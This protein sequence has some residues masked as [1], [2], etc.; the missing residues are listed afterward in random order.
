MSNN[1]N[2]GSNGGGATQT[3]ERCV[4]LANGA[5]SPDL[6]VNYEFG[7]V[8]GVDEFRQEQLYFLEKDRLHQRGL[9]GY[10]TVYGLG[11]TATA[12]ADASDERLIAVQPGLGIDQ[13]GRNIVLREEQCAR[14][15]AWLAGQIQ[16]G[17]A[18]PVGPFED[19]R[20]Y[21]V[22]TYDECEDAL[23]P[24]PGQ[25]CSTADTTQAP[26]RIRDG[27]QIELRWAPPLMTAWDA[28]RAFADVLA[29][30]RLVPGLAP[31]LSQEQEVIDLVRE[32]V[33]PP[34]MEMCDQTV[35]AGSPP[36]SP[37][38]SPPSGSPPTQT[39]QMPEEGAREALDRIFTVWVT[40]VRPHIAQQANL[41]DTDDDTK[42]ESGIL[43]AC[44]DFAPMDDF[45][46]N[47]PRIDHAHVSYVGRPYLLHTQ[48]I[49]EMLLL[50]NGDFEQRLE[51]REFA[52]LQ[53]LDGHTL[54]AWL[55]HP[56]PLEAVPSVVA[57]V[58]ILVDGQGVTLQSASA[59]AGVD[60]L[61]EIVTAVGAPN[62]LAP[63]SR[64]EAVFHVDAWQERGG[65]PLAEALEAAQHT[66][67]GR[68]G[69]TIHVYN[70]VDPIRPSRDLVSFETQRDDNGAMRLT[71]WFHTDQAVR[72]P[73]SVAVRREGGGAA[74]QFAASQI[75]GTGQFSFTWGF[76]PP[77]GTALNE[78][79]TLIF[80]FDARAIR[81]RNNQVTLADVIGDQ[82]L[83]FEGY[84][85]DRLVNVYYEVER[86]A[87]ATQ[88]PPVDI[89]EIIRQVAVLMPA[90]PF[91]D[92]TPRINQDIVTFEMWFHL[93]TEPPRDVM[94]IVEQPDFE[95]F[96]ETNEPAPATPHRIDRTLFQFGGSR[97]HNVFE[98]FIKRNDYKEQTNDSPYLRFMFSTEQPLRNEETG[99][100][101]RLR[102]YIEK[103][104]IKF[105]GHN[106]E[107]TLVKYVRLP[108]GVIG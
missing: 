95:V 14:L 48:L 54:R 107:K 65:W 82:H 43:L 11:V 8:L 90:L 32:L 15:G 68:D 97:Q 22:A 69:A 3:L 55:H 98:F 103:N 59:V 104:R 33:N 101:L 81:L 44:I 12:T 56:L 100:E 86:L 26:S 7:L 41:T 99:D 31:E 66:Y 24:V 71:G 62:R 38:G 4:S 46:A 74:Q 87:V 78:G 52:T 77:A 105:D 70:V 45:S 29:R 91:V 17:K 21:V 20:A 1:T 106:G 89:E 57:P 30:V 28:A 92:I 13:F 73:N 6:R 88:P 9:H 10:G 85:G 40:E 102:D 53:V 76:T 37:P 75:G 34:A 93:D 96:A 25:A 67:E 60:N 18:P 58:E 47:S 19:Y 16:Q 49:Q 108:Q 39:L 5:L 72:L 64:I 50:G 36:S 51:A 27:F 2:N 83:S 23:V 94:R 80:A 79:D 63:G 42:V 61:F 84:D 35:A